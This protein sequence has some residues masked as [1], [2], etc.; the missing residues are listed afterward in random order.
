MENLTFADSHNMIAYLEKSIENVDFTEI[1]DFLMLAILDETVHED[2]GDRVERVATTASSLEAK[3]DSGN[4]LRTQSMTTLNEPIPQGTGLA[5]SRKKSRTLQ[6]KR[7]LFKVRIESSSDKN[8]GDQE[9]T[10]NQERNDQDEGISFVQEDAETQVTTGG[11]FVGTIEFLRT[12]A[13]HSKETD[14]IIEFVH[15]KS[16]GE[17][18][19]QLV[20]G[21][22]KVQLNRTLFYVLL[23]EIKLDRYMFHS[24]VLNRV[25]GYGYG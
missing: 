25:A 18:V 22:D 13:A 17:D 3:Q 24:G 19:G 10:S 5:G 20:I 4:I 6:L 12:Q 7:R 11:V 21:L 1:V 14:Q 16:F 8:L 2:R 9:D 23:D 15:W